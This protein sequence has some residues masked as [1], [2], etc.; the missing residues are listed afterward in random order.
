MKLNTI[1]SEIFQIPAEKLQDETLLKGIPT[2]DS[3][4][5]M[6]LIVRVEETF[7]IQFAGD[8]IA[9]MKTLG[10]IR[11]AVLAHGGQP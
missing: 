10:D 3:L 2:W 9:D 6:M 5:H 7:S 4:Q 11:R 1:F 8:E